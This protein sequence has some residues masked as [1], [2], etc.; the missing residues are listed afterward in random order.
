MTSSEYSGPR[1]PDPV[2]VLNGAENR[3][4]VVAAGRQ[5]VLFAHEWRAPGRAS[6]YLAPAVDAAL[7]FLGLEPREL[8]GLAV[9]RGPGSF[10]GLRMTMAFALGLARAARLPMAGIDYLP[11][12]ASGP[13]A[14]L[15]GTLAVLAH[16]RT[17]EVYVQTFA[18]P[19]LAPLAPP[20]ALGLDEI[21]PALSG[22]PGP[23]RLMGSGLRRNKAALAERLPGLQILPEYWDEPSS[24]QLCAAALAAEYQAAPP[25]PLYIRPSDAEENLARIAASRGVD[26]EEAKRRLDQ[27]V[28]TISG[29][30]PDLS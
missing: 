3:L 13:G 18:C 20:K 23:V 4:A 25:R 6:R 2:L 9:V 21:G 11:L 26:A 22:L 14:L 28:R 29:N 19:G 1:P 16:S 27:A 8:G 7:E 12:V 17:R 15:D 30:G 10:T 5:G 24:T